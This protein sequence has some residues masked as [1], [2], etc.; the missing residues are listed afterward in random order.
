MLELIRTAI[1]KTYF[2]SCWAAP[3]PYEAFLNAI[4]EKIDAKLTEQPTHISCSIKSNG[5]NR[6]R[7]DGIV[8]TSNDQYTLYVDIVWLPKVDMFRGNATVRPVV[9]ST[10]PE[11]STDEEDLVPVFVPALGTLLAEME[12]KNGTPLTETEVLAIRDK[13]I[14]IALRRSVAAEMDE[15]RGY[16]DVDP[17]NCWLEWLA[18]RS[19][20]TQP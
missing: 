12:R 16:R 4:A 1:P 10:S 18:L 8:A 13:A 15:R 3:P 7:L 17:K 14:C 2:A 9:T 5:D 11:E 20:Q 19:Q 6:I